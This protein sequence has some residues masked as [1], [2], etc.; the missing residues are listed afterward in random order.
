V[1]KNAKVII[2]GGY[3]NLIAQKLKGIHE[4]NDDL[5]LTG[6]IQVYKRLG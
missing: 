3:G 2:T 4:V 1:G 5:T 6:L